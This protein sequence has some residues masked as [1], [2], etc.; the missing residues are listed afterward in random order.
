[1]Y[2]LRPDATLLDAIAA[3]GGWTSDGD[4]SAIIL[5]V[6][7]SDHPEVHGLGAILH[8]EAVNPGLGA[9]ATVFVPTRD[10]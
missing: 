4:T 7:G 2:S 1:M 3:A 9:G 8:G 10:R 6:A 5:T